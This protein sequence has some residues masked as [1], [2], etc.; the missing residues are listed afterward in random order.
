[1]LFALF[2]SVFD[3][4][5]TAGIGL[6]GLT[7]QVMKLPLASIG[8]GWLIPAAIGFVIAL[9]PIGKKCGEYLRRKPA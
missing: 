7:E 1:M 3:G 2:F 6:G 8:V 4:F 9:T 5:K